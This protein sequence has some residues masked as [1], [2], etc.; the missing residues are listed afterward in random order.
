MIA[1]Y[2]LLIGYLP[3]AALFRL[4]WMDRDRR[5]ALDVEE[6]AF[7]AVVLSLAASLSIVLGLAALGRYSFERLLVANLLVAAAAALASRG[8]LSFAGA[9][10]RPG[11]SL[12][13]PLLLILVGLWRFFPPNEYVMGGKDPGVYMNAGIQIGQRGTLWFDDPVVADVPAFAWDLFFPYYGGDAYYSTRFMGFFLM[14]PERGTVVSQFPHLY[15]ASIAI[16]YGVDGL[17]GARRA[18]GVWAL[19][20]VLAVY[21]CA[22]HLFGRRAAALGAGLL[23]LHV[24]QVWFARYPNA[25]VAMQALAFAALLASARAHADGLRFFAPVAGA[26]LGLMLFLRVDA[27]FVIAAAAG[28]AAAGALYGVRTPAWLWFVLAGLGSIAAVYLAGPMRAHMERPLIYATNLPAAGYAALAAVVAL[29]VV[30]L[31]A[32][33]RTERLRPIVGRWLPLG[34]GVA[35]A[36]AAIYALFFRE[37]AG[38]LAA[39]DAYALRT[40]AHLYVTVPAV[41]AAVAGYAIYAR[42]LFWKAPAFFFA[43]LLFSVFFFYKIQIVPEHFWMAR[44]FVPVILPMTM[45]LAAAFAFGEGRGL[46]SRAVQWTAGLLFIALLAM[47]YQRIARPILDHGDYAGMIPKLEALAGRI[48]DD[49]LVIAESRAAGGDIHVLATPL[50]YIYAR[51]VLLLATP[52]PDKATFARFLEEA[53]SRYQRVLFLGSGGTDLLS[54][55]Y[56]VRAVESDR[57]QVPEYQ[58]TTDALP[59][60]S[61]MKE[62]D[63]GLY[64][65]TPAETRDGLWFDLDLGIRDDLH[66]LRFYAKEE[67]DG[68]TFRWTQDQSFVTVTIVPAGA[69]EVRF[70]MHN[71][72]RPAAAPPA[73]LQVYFHGAPL[74]TIRVE[75]GW[76][77]YAVAIPGAVAARAA[78]AG[79]PVELRLVTTTWNPRDVLGTPDDR[80]LGVMV[81]RVAV[82]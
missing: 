67:T 45:V 39:H 1:L 57:F 58:T 38:R 3:G 62:F 82:R 60:F 64:E 63:Y 73:D 17:T 23:A 11:L 81:D 79:D 22:A 13:L 31:V 53:R 36:A 41:L 71:G 15:P 37:P 10:R 26:L 44:R 72:G 42:R 56:G 32:G 50:A 48:A 74:G 51:N 19:L 75:D 28:G 46:R 52:R 80:E 6:R 59:R 78:A 25:E 8:R 16:G 54:H 69:R 27:V 76:R 29:A 49:D 35:L 70:W 4:P 34:A 24:V 61:T 65:F 20:G 7:W 33:S 55:R 40:Y 18:S 5:A 9:A 21:F 77:E 12:L 43:A 47:H 14:D 30:A 66:V 68:R 2:L